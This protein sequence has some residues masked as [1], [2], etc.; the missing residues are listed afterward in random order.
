MKQNS[1]DNVSLF[2]VR[3]ATNSTKFRVRGDG[4]VQAGNDAANPFMATDPHDVVTKKYLEQ[5]ITPA[6]SNFTWY[7]PSFTD[8]GSI[9]F[10]SIGPLPA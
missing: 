6:P 9:I 3:N 10:T 1:K 7:E 8:V 2:Y 5:A 4:K